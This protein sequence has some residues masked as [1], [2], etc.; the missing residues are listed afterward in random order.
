MSRNGTE[1]WKKK[2][3]P[4]K[5]SSYPD[6]KKG[7]V[8]AKTDQDK[9]N[10]F[11][12][13]LKSVLETKIELKDKNLEKEI[14]NFLMLNIQD[15]SPLKIVDDHEELISIIEIY[16]IINKSVIKKAPFYDRIDMNKL[17][18]L[19]Q[20]SSNFYTSFSSC[21]SILVFT[22]QTRKLQKQLYCRNLVN[23]KI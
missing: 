3:Y 1:L 15:Y 2:C 12:E 16:K 10:Q 19:S 13:Q 17:N 18:I 4:S 7:T 20:V 8:I 11:P 6:L 14:G 9:L 23:Q 21:E 22:L 5:G